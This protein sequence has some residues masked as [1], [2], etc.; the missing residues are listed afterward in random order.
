MQMN[1]FI[2]VLLISLLSSISFASKPT[3][4]D[5]LQRIIKKENGNKK[6]EALIKLSQFMYDKNASKGINIGFDAVTASK[7]LSSIIYSQALENLGSLYQKTSNYE[8]AIDYY[9]KALEQKK[10]DDGVSTIYDNIG[11]SFGEIGKFDS[12]LFY[13]QQSLKLCGAKGDHKGSAIAINYMGNVNVRN[14]NYET[15]LNF[16]F[17]ALKIREENDYTEDIA[18]SLENIGDTYKKLNQYDKALEYLNRALVLRNTIGDNSKIAY[19]FNSFGNFYMQV[20][21]FEKALDYYSKSLELR[22]QIGDKKDIAASYNNIGTLH[23]E[24][25]NFDKALEYYNKALELRKQTGNKEAVAASFNSI[26]S[27]HWLK[28]DYKNAIDNYKLA[29]KIRQ[30][31][32]EKIQIAATL[33]NLGII[34]KDMNDFPT[35]LDYYQQS[36]EISIEVNDL[37]GVAS[38]QNLKGNLYKKSKEFDKAIEFYTNAHNLYKQ[39]NQRKEMA[40]V[41]NNLG[42]IYN[43]EKQTAKAIL[44]YNEAY[45]ISTEIKDKNTAK[46]AALGL[47]NVYKTT[48]NSAKGLEFFTIYSS[49]KDSIQNDMNKKRIAEMEFDTEIKI[50]DNELLQQEYK[51]KGTE[52]ELSRQRAFIVGTIVVIILIA[53]FTVLVLIQ[54]SQK[55]KAFVLLAEKSSQ[56]E[57]ANNQL[58]DKNKELGIKNDQITDS[59]TYAKQIQEA[60]LPPSELISHHFPNHFV[61]YRPKEIVSGD[62]YWFSVQENYLFIAVVDCTGHGVPGAFMSMIGNTLLN[63]IINVQKTYDTAEIL[64]KLDNGVI[65]ALKQDSS[66]DKRQEDGMDITLCRIDKQSGTV[67]VALA[68]H[69]L[70]IIKN[71]ELSFIEGDSFAIGGMYKIKQR[72]QAKYESHSFP[73]EK[74]MKLYMHSDGIIDQFGGNDNERFKTPNFHKLLLETQQNDMHEQ[75][76]TINQRFDEWKGIR[77]QLD[78]VMVIGIEL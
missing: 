17:K 32:D 69:R 14:G 7:N 48:G 41:A 42:E 65:H 5:S 54:F 62:F 60:I 18:A 1:K 28:K 10:T 52:A 68:N 57:D 40:L 20:K 72:K 6:I 61:M 44:S 3:A 36:I 39:I 49:L 45:S 67:D 51:L 59:I 75:F 58:A 47:A 77:K 29:L 27:L 35:S 73:I 53:L 23:R 74:G 25:Q 34:Y 66:S 78:D 22:I 16:Y 30:E 24:L 2:S 50:K 13:H 38:I 63:E 46:D 64:Q 19:C 76:L 15:A 55:K 71:G 8:S 56:L 11:F 12:A 9:K 70:V 43:Q 33:K 31:L 26:G 4:I 21:I 37:I